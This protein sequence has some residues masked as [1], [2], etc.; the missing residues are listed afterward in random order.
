MYLLGTMYVESRVNLKIRLLNNIF[1]RTKEDKRCCITYF[2]STLCS[3]RQ[4]QEIKLEI[5]ATL[6]STNRGL[7]IVEEDRR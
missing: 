5:L 2:L 3:F 6:T 1:E 7:I 4:L